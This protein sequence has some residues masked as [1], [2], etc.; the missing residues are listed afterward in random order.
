MRLVAVSG[1]WLQAEPGLLGEQQV[2]QGAG[3]SEGGSEGGE[4]GRQ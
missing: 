2:R 4:G 3:Q 1:R